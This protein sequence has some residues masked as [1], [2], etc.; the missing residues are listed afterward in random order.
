MRR[1]G[2]IAAVQSGGFETCSGKCVLVAPLDAVPKSDVQE[3]HEEY[4]TGR[5]QVNCG[6]RQFCGCVPGRKD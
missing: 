3:V 6:E 1:I 2:S 4:K 5:K